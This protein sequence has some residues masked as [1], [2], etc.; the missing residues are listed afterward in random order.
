MSNLGIFGDSYTHVPEHRLNDKTRNDLSWV[1]IVASNLKTKSQNFSLSG[2]SIYFAFEKFID[3]YKDYDTIIFSYSSHI[4]YPYF[5]QGFQFLSNIGT[6]GKHVI[7]NTTGWTEEHKKVAKNFLEV[8]PYIFSE[9]LQL[10]LYQ[11]IFNDVN[12]LC[13]KN[14]I[15]I[16]NI[17]SFENSNFLIDISER[18]G[19]C[20]TSLHEVSI[21]E[22][23]T[24]LSNSNK[25]S[26]NLRNNVSV[27]PRFNHL[28]KINN[29][30]LAKV[31]L[32]NIDTKN[33]IDFSKVDDLT[34]DD[35]LLEY[36]YA[37]Y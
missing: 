13:Y 22:T 18:K 12:D 24:Q 33:I 3:N 29:Q 37:F 7:D 26:Y 34:Y 14:N 35:N 15:K 28:N 19:V 27:D 25:L 21:K 11:K 20:V 4:R 5:K 30:I 31:V 10:Y 16:I 23:T 17:M 36:N 6:H 8:H 32:D 2:T 9:R 1:E